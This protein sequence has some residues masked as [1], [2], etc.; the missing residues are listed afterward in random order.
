MTTDAL[1]AILDR[2]GYSGVLR[3][4][5]AIADES[6]P[7]IDGGFSEAC[8]WELVI[9]KQRFAIRRTIAV[10]DKMIDEAS[11]LAPD[12]FGSTNDKRC[13]KWLRKEGFKVKRKKTN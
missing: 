12:C 4:I 10:A 1:C 11:F 8:E 6:A 13:R 3:A 5:A 7:R 2:I 9:A